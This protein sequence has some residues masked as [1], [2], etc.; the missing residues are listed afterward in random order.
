MGCHFI[1]FFFLEFDLADQVYYF[2]EMPTT[3]IEGSNNQYIQFHK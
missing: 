1:F 2:S 3:E